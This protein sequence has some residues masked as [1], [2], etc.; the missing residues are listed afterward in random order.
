[1]IRL[2]IVDDHAVLRES[3]A[4]ALA[5]EPDMT[6]TA[7]CGTVEEALAVLDRDPIDVVI[8]DYDLGSCRGTEFAA[9]ARVAGFAGRILVLTAGLSDAVARSLLR[10]GAAGIIPKEKPLSAV[11]DAVR[12]V[13]SGVTLVE[14]RYLPQLLEPA[15]RDEESFNERQRQ[16]LRQVVSGRTN[17]QIAKELGTSEPAVK[18]ALRKLFARTGT[19]TRAQLVR[20]V[21]ESYRD[22][23]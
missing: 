6:V 3:V 9:A 5:A 2:L 10:G 15:S 8:L 7:D 17:K 16:I 11:I 12:A 13:A 4:R 20:V 23:M 14:N 1:M 19:Q 21:L 18:G 22:L